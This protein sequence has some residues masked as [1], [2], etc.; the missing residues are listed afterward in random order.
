M[1]IDAIVPR[2]PLNRYSVS[3]GPDF[4]LSTA[5]VRAVI[6]ATGLANRMQ[7][8]VDRSHLLSSLGLIGHSEAVNS[9]SEFP[10]CLRACT[11]M[12]LCVASIRAGDGAAADA[13]Y[14]MARECVDVAVGERPSQHL[15]S[16]LLLMAL[17]SLPLGRSE[18]EALENSAFAQRL[19]EFVPGL[20][21]GILL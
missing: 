10:A 15:I 5:T 8:I 3:A 1:F 11:F 2:V 20:C 18:S 9:P 19:S 21:P 12:L 13:N 6:E 4:V 17:L 16:A 7:K 14:Q